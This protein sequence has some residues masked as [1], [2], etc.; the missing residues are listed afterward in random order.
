MAFRDYRKISQLVDELDEQYQHINSLK[1]ELKTIKSL[2]EYN[3]LAAKINQLVEEY[4]EK[5]ENVKNAI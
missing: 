5:R 1:A 3:E 4:N 2:D